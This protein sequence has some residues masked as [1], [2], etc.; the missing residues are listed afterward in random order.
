MSI[1]GENGAKPQTAARWILDRDLAGVVASDSHSPT[2]R[3]PTL[4]AAYHYLHERY[5]PE[6]AMRLCITNP[7]AAA[8]GQEIGR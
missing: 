7:R 1:V 3:P 8:T 4:R 5:G 6:R 2:W